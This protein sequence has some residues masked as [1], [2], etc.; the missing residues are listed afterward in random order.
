MGL[1]L[2]IVASILKWIFQPLLWSYGTAV[3]IY[4]H[5]Y[6]RWEFDKAVSK[7]QYGNVLGKYLFNHILIRKDGHRFGN[8]DETISSVLGK[9]EQAKT[10]RWLGKFI[11]WVLNTIDPGHTKKAIGS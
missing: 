2:N 4:R 10:L 6:N 3:S 5:E 9:N 11:A 8:P 7:D 1:V